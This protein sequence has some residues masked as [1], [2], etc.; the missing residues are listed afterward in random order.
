[1][2]FFLTTVRGW[3]SIAVVTKNSTLVLTGVLDVLCLK[4]K[5]ANLI[6]TVS[7]E[8]SFTN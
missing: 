8:Q 4:L 3:K 7:M 2:K 6:S 5:F 1:M